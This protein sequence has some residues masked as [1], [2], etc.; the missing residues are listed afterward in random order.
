MGLAST[1]KFLINSLGYLAEERAV[2]T[3]SGNTD[4]N[5]IPALNTAGILD[6]SIINSSVTS[7]PNK[8]PKLNNSGVLDITVLPTG[9]GVDTAAIV[10]SETLVAG[11]FVN[12]WNS[13]GVGKVRLADGSTTGKIVNGFVLSGVSSGSIA[14]VYFEGTNTQCSGLTPGEQFLSESIPGKTTSTP[15]S[16]IPGS[17]CQYVGVAISPTSINF[18]PSRPIK[19]A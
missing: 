3:S 17:V 14:T 10:A 6:D 13:A 18:E 4:S 19:I 5:K 2:T 7:S 16:T 12:V 8:I 1:T 15:P 9:V 11:D